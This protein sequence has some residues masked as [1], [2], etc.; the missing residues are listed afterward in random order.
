MATE[1]WLIDKHD[2][3]KQLRGKCVAK[4]PSTFIM[5]LFAAADEIAHMPTVDAVDVVRCKNCKAY[6]NGTCWIM[7]GK[8]KPDDFCS[9]GESR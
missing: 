5:G 7:R 6:S 8:M 1:K 4:Y 9:Y 3:I 2:A